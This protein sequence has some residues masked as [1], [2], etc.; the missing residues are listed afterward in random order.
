MPRQRFSTRYKNIKEREK[1]YN[2][3]TF[4][5][6]SENVQFLSFFFFFMERRT[7][8]N[9]ETLNFRQKTT[10]LQLICQ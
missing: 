7:F 3:G 4:L 9:V 6:L 1:K 10:I 5:Q 2:P 8:K